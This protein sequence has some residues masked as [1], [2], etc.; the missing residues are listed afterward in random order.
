MLIHGRHFA[1]CATLP[2]ASRCQ[3]FIHRLQRL[4]DCCMPGGG[5]AHS[6]SAV[7]AHRR[8][9]RGRR[10]FVSRLPSSYRILMYKRAELRFIVKVD[11]LGLANRYRQF[12]LAK[13]PFESSTREAN[14]QLSHGSD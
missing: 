10:I 11:Q 9:Q 6:V 14:H 3:G 5:P 7:P 1:E 13:S 4:P 2:T 12:S 8:Q